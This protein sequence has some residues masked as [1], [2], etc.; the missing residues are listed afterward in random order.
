MSSRSGKKQRP[1]AP[2]RSGGSRLFK[3]VIAGVAVYF[4]ISIISLQNEVQKRQMEYDALFDKCTEQ[5][6]ANKELE[7]RISEGD[8]EDYIVRTARE[9]LDYVYP[10]EKVFINVSGS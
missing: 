4:G 9:R 10:Y 7:M 1:A 3:L 5:E 8:D 6:M 2:R